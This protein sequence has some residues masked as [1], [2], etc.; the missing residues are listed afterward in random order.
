MH[1]PPQV[2]DIQLRGGPEA[3]ALAR[4][5]VDDLNGYV[6]EPVHE[7][8]RLL[9]TEVVGNAVRH[10]HRSGPE[11]VE[12]QVSVDPGSS[13]RIEI[14]DHGPGFTPHVE[15]GREEGGGWGLFLLDRV[16][17]RWGVHANGGARVWFELDLDD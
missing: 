1:S 17:D 10:G 15:H 11:P 8:L 2:Q 7:D 6:S 14:A 5:I 9:V 4:K 12:L 16:A 3:P 13:V